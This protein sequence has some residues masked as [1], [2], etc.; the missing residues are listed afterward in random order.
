MVLAAFLWTFSARMHR[1]LMLLSVLSKIN[2]DY[3]QI[4]TTVG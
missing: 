2:E 4:L 1:F 3:R